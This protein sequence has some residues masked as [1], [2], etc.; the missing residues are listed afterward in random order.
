MP[1]SDHVP[2]DATIDWELEVADSPLLQTLAYVFPSILGGVVV[3]SG[4]LLVWLLFQAV[5][6]GN[7]ARVIGLVVISLLG[8]LTRRYLP[9]LLTT[10]IVD[11]FRERYSRRGL[12]VGSVLGAI[13]LLGSTRLHPD[14]PFVVFVASWV[15][16]VLTAG[17][18]MSGHVDPETETLVVDGT[19]VPVDAVQGFRRVRIGAFVICWLSYL[20]GS[21]SAP[22]IIVLPSGSFES[23]SQLVDRAS[24]SAERE[25]STIDRTERV[26][27]SL[28]G[29]GMVAIGPVLWIILPPGDG[30]LVAL[31]AGALFGLFGIVLLWYAYSA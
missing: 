1:E 20:R 30:Q 8:L 13:V 31:Y 9:A 27:A 4:A 6:T 23:V 21:P 11:P 16:L 24:G 3:L 26:V 29:L 10:N 17:F 15:P 2:D 22:R 12:V 7:F 5:L 18:P 14:A 25:P 28:F 19:E